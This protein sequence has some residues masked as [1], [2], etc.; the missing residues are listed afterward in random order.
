MPKLSEET[1][2]RPVRKIEVA[3]DV[4]ILPM[5]LRRIPAIAVTEAVMKNVTFEDGTKGTAYIFVERVHDAWLRVSEAEKLPLGM[6]AEVIM[7][8]IRTGFVEGS[9]GAP[10]NL[11]V[12]VRSLLDHIEQ[13]RE[14]PE[15]WTPERRRRFKE[16]DRY[17]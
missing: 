13:T 15:F 5:E 16:G 6:S 7:K 1:F 11:M 9:Q 14:D 3:P 4:R 12:N 10:C 2:P 17:H 8:L